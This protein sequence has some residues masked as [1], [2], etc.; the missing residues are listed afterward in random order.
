MLIQLHHVPRSLQVRVFGTMLKTKIRTLRAVWT[1]Q[2]KLLPTTTNTL[3]IEAGCA[4]KKTRNLIQ[5]L[6][7]MLADDPDMSVL[8][9]TTRKTHA[10]DLA[11]TLVSELEGTQLDF[12]GGVLGGTIAS[13]RQLICF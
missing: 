7:A 5:W 3:L 1:G 9:V 8:F 2:T 6:K 11:A 12:W 13:K 4:A 10:E